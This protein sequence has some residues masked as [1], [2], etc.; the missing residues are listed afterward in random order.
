VKAYQQN[1]LYGI[2]VEAAFISKG[3][4]N[5]KDA[6]VNKTASLY[7]ISLPTNTKDIGE[8][9]CA[10]TIR[11]KHDNRQCFMTHVP[12][13]DRH[14]FTVRRLPDLENVWRISESGRRFVVQFKL[15]IAYLL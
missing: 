4:F 14:G 1:K 11:E 2:S 12:D 9:L 5:W 7:M 15:N 3:Y 13:V 8:L 6:S 10:Q